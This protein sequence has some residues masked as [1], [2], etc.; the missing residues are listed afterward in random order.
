MGE[1]VKLKDY[2]NR[3]AP[4]AERSVSDIMVPVEFAVGLAER[5][6]CLAKLAEYA[7]SGIEVRIIK[8]EPDALGYLMSVKDAIWLNKKILELEELSEEEVAVRI[9]LI[10]MLENVN[11]PM[12]QSL[13]DS[14]TDKDLS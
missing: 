11:L 4:R 5:N 12:M 10:Q 2:Q 9:D 3:A 6:L 13:W 1:V 14:F 8:N 7:V